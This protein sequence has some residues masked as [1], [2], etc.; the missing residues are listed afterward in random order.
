MFKFILCMLLLVGC[1]FVAVG[2]LR[3]ANKF[4]WSEDTA[5]RS[6]R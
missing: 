6:S 3:T 5:V 1:Y 2:F 4:G